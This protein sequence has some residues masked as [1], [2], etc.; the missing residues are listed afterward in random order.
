[1][2]DKYGWLAIKETAEKHGIDRNTFTLRINL[3]WDKLTAATKPKRKRKHPDEFYEYKKIAEKNGVSERTYYMRVNAGMG[4]QEAA[5][6]PVAFRSNRKKKVDK[7]IYAIY[8]NDEMIFDGYAEECAEFMKIKLTSFYWYLTPTGQKRQENRVNKDK[9]FY[10]V[11]L[12]EDDD[13]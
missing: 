9:V 5:T 8:R 2:E 3:G 10:I 4:Y 11:D 13:E 12:G 1:M 7:N 6:K